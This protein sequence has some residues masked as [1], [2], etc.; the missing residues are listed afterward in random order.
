MTGSQSMKKLGGGRSSLNVFFT[1]RTNK[2]VCN[3][4]CNGCYLFRNYKP[5][6]EA[7]TADKVPQTIEQMRGAGFEVFYPITTEILLAPNW[8]EILK[9][10]GDEYV[11]TNGRIVASRGFDI[12]WE[13]ERCGVKQIIITANISASHDALNL[14]DKKTVQKAFEVIAKYNDMH[15]GA[16]KTVATVIITSENFD[17][18]E[19]LC[20]HV[21]KAYKANAVKFIAFIPFSDELL[22]LSPTI[23]QLKKVAEQIETVRS[24]YPA[25]RLYIQRGGT[26]GA[27]GLTEAKVAKLCPAGEHVKGIKSLEDG[28][29]VTPCI[30]FPDFEIG[31]M[32][33]G[34]VT[35]HDGYEAFIKLK[36]TALEAG[37]CPAHAHAL[38][39]V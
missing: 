28:A 13:L 36:Q 16:F 39:M 2:P 7:I 8:Q 6:A 34:R 12:L 10:T 26:L 21:L 22:H 3:E 14:T 25:E 29:P 18:V 1:P 31:T 38:G 4:K 15:S 9:A 23:E 30:Y 33:N 19:Q 24:K 20:E 35:L 32:Q 37:Y 5:K 17:K 27:Q 11:N